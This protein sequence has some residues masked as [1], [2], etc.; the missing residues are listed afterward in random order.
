MHMFPAR[1]PIASYAVR[2]LLRHRVSL[3]W[4]CLIVLV[5]CQFAAAAHL[6]TSGTMNDGSRPAAETVMPGNHDGKTLDC[7]NE[8]N[9]CCPIAKSIKQS[10]PDLGA[11]LLPLVPEHFLLV[12]SLG[13]ASNPA[14]RADAELPLRPPPHFLGR[15][16]I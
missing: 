10:V 7:A 4:L 5:W 12:R 11:A 14:I 8:D 3:V 2:R 15:L 9:D 16:L 13:T 6:C 1:R